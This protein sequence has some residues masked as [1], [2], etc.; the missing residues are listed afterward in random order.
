ME[1]REERLYKHRFST[2]I[3]LSDRF[4]FSKSLPK[5]AVN[6]FMVVGIPDFFVNESFFAT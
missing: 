4:F 1:F 6:G 3:S 2:L 5:S